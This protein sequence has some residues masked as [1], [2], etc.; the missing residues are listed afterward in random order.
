MVDLNFYRD[1]FSG[2]ER[3]FDLRFSIYFRPKSILIEA[4]CLSPN[5]ILHPKNP[6]YIYSKFGN[7]EVKLSQNAQLGK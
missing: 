2:L 1:L 5:T 7:L 6:T 4:Q 3:I